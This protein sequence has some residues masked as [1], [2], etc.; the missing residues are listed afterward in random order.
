[1]SDRKKAIEDALYGRKTHEQCVE[2]LGHALRCGCK[3]CKAY[4]ADFEK[5]AGGID[6]HIE[7]IGKYENILAC[8]RENGD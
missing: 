2:W 5:Y 4:V 8:L 6:V 7:W 1:M 3:E